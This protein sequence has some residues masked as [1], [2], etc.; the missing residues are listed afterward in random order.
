MHHLAQRS[1]LA[2][3]NL[4]GLFAGSFFAAGSLTAFIDINIFAPDGFLNCL[5]VYPLGLAHPYAPGDMYFMPA[6]GWKEGIGGITLRNQKSNRP[7][8]GDIHY[9]PDGRRRAACG[10]LQSLGLDVASG[11][12]ARSKCHAN[13]ATARDRFPAL[14]PGRISGK[15]CYRPGRLW[16]AVQIVD[17]V[18]AGPE[19]PNHRSRTTS[20][21]TLFILVIIN[22]VV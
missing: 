8:G 19:K 2:I 3:L 13:C 16:I 7:L 18:S 5:R 20:V 12:H 21:F 11:R 17:T 15:N 10:S 1:I 4:E 14:L 6:E 22:M 9:H